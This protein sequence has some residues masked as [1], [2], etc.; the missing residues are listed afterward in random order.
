MMERLIKMIM[1]TQELAREYPELNVT[2]DVQGDDE[3]DVLNIYGTSIQVNDGNHISLL[4]FIMNYTPPEGYEM[5][6][7]E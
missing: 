3:C 7:E 6:S 4:H 2:I 1:K 5:L